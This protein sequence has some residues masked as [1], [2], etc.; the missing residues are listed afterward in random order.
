[1]A[2][3]GLGALATA[4]IAFLGVG[5]TGQI[6]VF[7]IT[8]LIVFFAVK[9]VFD[10]FFHRF[11]DPQ[12]TGIEALVGQTGKVTDDIISGASAG[13]VQIGGE[14]WQAR[15]ADAVDIKAETMVTIIRIE[16]ATAFV[17]IKK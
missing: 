4:V 9:P 7:A 10:K 2:S 13:R 16:G 5:M 3:L 12:K 14:N 8:T 1:M 11:D 6:L 17:E 15:S